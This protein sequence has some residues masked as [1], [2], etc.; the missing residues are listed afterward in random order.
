M[1]ASSKKVSDKNNQQFFFSD[2]TKYKDGKK[3]DSCNNLKFTFN[4]YFPEYL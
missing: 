4:K 3:I 1:S 2:F